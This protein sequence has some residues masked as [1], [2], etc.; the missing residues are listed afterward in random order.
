MGVRKGIDDK[1]VQIG[2]EYNTSLY[3]LWHL[4]VKP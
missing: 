4:I 1:I 3:L 2:E